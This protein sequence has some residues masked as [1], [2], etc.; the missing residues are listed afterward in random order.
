MTKYCDECD[1]ELTD[2]DKNKAGHYRDRCMDCIQAK[3]DELRPDGG[4]ARSNTRTYHIE[5]EDSEGDRRKATER[6]SDSDLFGLGEND[7]EAVGHYLD[8]L[9]ESGGDGDA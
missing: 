8:L 6:G 1:A 5:V 4:W 2:E 7:L 3:A 9:R